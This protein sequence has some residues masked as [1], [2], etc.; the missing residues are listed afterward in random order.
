MKPEEQK[1]QLF[2]P[3]WN[4]MKKG[5]LTD[6]E[7]KEL[8]NR[9]WKKDVTNRLVEDAP[10]VFADPDNPTGVM[11]RRVTIPVGTQII[12]NENTDDIILMGCGNSGDRVIK[13]IGQPL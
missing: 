7:V 3:N 10:V 1:A 5:G 4:P 8:E 2:D 6:D 12:H 13:P 9:G 11:I